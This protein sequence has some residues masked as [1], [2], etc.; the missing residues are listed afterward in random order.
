MPSRPGRLPVSRRFLLV[1]GAASLMACSRR[2]TDSPHQAPQTVGSALAE[3]RTKYGVPAMAAIV[4]TA[5][6][7]LDC[8]ALGIAR[9]GHGAAVSALS[10]FH[11]GSN[12]KAITATMVA[13][14]VEQKRLSWETTVL[15]VFPEWRDSIHPDYR[16]INLNDLFQHHAGLPPYNNAS[17]RDMRSLPKGASVKDQ[18]AFVLRRPPTQKPGSGGLYSNAGPAIAAVMAE[19]VTGSSWRDLVSHRVFAPLG[20]RG[21]FGWPNAA[22]STQPSGH[23]HL[24]LGSVPTPTFLIHPLPPLL[25]PSGDVHMSLP[26][27]A[28]FLQAHLKGLQGRDDLLTAATVRHLHTPRGVYGLGWGVGPHEGRLTS[29]HD[30]SDGTFYATAAL[31]HECDLAIAVAANM[32]GDMASQACHAVSKTVARIYLEKIS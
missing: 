18:A 16:G 12:T 3:S 15:D 10:R 2:R 29:G 6:Q 13:T 19:R 4:L 26:D 32:G 30:G 24:W 27:Y 5:N 31:W 7:V 17:S 1:N 25:Q 9:R 20:I 22:D 21:G 14:L 11:L 8:Q 23:V 28:R